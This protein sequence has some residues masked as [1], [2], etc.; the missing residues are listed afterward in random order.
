[1]MQ[2]LILL[3]T[4]FVLPVYLQVVLGL[5]AFETGKRLFPMSVA[6]FLAAMAGPGWPPAS[7]RSASRR[8]ALA[9]A[10]VASLVLLGTI[11]VELNEAEFAVALALFGVGAGLLLSQ[12]G[13]VIMSS[14]DRRRPTRPAACRAP[15]RTSARRSAPR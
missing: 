9:L 11:D 1:M 4:F 6:M 3:G 8:P 15:R 14:V 2:Q 10:L 12:L 5:D 7:P 13:N